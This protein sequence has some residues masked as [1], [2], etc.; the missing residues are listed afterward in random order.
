MHGSGRIDAQTVKQAA[1]EQWP[2]ILSQ[3]AS[4]P[5]T[6]LDGKQHGCP[7]CGGK[8]RFRLIDLNAGAVLCNQCFNKGNGDGLAA[9]MHFRGVDF[10]EALHLVA[11]YLGI[12]PANG[13]RDPVEQ[14][15]IGRMA[16]VK[17]CPRQSLAVYG[18]EGQSTRKAV[19]FPVYAPDGRQCSTFTVWPLAKPGS[20]ELKGKLAHGKPSGVFLPHGD[21][22]EPIV[23]RPGTTWLVVEGVKDAAALHDLGYFVMGMN[24]DNFPQKFVR[25]FRGVHVLIV[26]DRTTCAEAKA[27]E[28]ASRL[29]GVAA[30][31]KVASLPLPLDGSKGDDTRDALKQ[32]DGESLLREAIENAPAW[33]S[34]SRAKNTIGEFVPFPVETLPEPL[35]GFISKGAAALGCDSAYLA[36][37]LL[38]VLASAIGNTR[39]IRIKGCWHEPC[40]IWAVVIGESGTL[41]SPAF[42]LSVALLRKRQTIAYREYEERLVRYEQDE[43]LY[44]ADFLEWK[45]KGRKNG[46]PPPEKPAPPLWEQMVAEDTTIEALAELLGDQPRGL[47]VARDELSGWLASFDAYKK[48]KGADVSHWL[49]MHRGGELLVNRKG[50]R[51]RIRIASAS[52]SVCGG[53]QPTRL[54]SLLGTEH[55]ENGLAARLL[56]A[57]PPRKP[58]RWTDDDLTPCDREPIE[59]LID[60]LLSLSMS[61]DEYG[62]Q[63]PINIPLTSEAEQR[64][65]SFY[66]AHN[67]EQNDLS[68]E[69]AA[70]WSKLEGYAARLALLC[71]LVSNPGS[72]VVG[73]DNLNV[74]ISLAR[75]FADEAARIY[76]DLGGSGD[77]E[78]ARE[79]RALDRVSDWISKQGGE[80][81]ARDVQRNLSQYSTAREAEAVL[82]RLASTGLG[83]WEVRETGGRPAT[84][85]CLA[86]MTDTDTTPEYPPEI[87]LASS[88]S[89]ESTVSS[90][91]Q[92][93]RSS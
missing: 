59:R 72:E 81:T 61:E 29:S 93:V 48:T 74:G 45:R 7:L 91:E 46:E 23:P 40:I 2:A 34:N 76:G 68:G 35:R 28:S 80:V 70:A 78:A 22:R 92:E 37:P 86:D 71:E 43:Q 24:G 65:I 53:I 30:S 54:A 42:D 75:W 26:P 9:V 13:N 21:D 12:S 31:V 41:K 89:T 33:T 62:E 8:D 15:W 79:K 69:L 87:D 5:S 19:S 88:V 66:N 3:V 85:F 60:Q 83:K 77:S 58:K 25:M 50:G 11:E 84:V 4:I 18:A 56:L 52:V 38:A 27:Q 10:P 32:A 36:L 63:Q 47:L 51:K 39:R 55:F 57:K 1:R 14:D 49:S 82:D 90:T 6:H 64:W 44:E 20:K 16:T 67:E 73:V 17:S